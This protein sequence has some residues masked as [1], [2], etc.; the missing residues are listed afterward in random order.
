MILFILMSVFL[1]ILWKKGKN[2]IQSLFKT[3]H[4]THY[5]NKGSLRISVVMPFSSQDIPQILST[6]NYWW[7][8][9][10]TAYPCAVRGMSDNVI[11]SMVLLYDKDLEEGHDPSPSNID[12]LAPHSDFVPSPLATSADHSAAKKLR[13]RIEFAEVRK[14]WE[15]IGD[16]SEER[17]RMAKTL[18][19]SHIVRLLKLKWGHYGFGKCFKGG[20]KFISAKS[21]HVHE[22]LA[23]EN[24]CHTFKRGLDIT[25]RMNQDYI[26]YMEPTV[27]PIRKFWLDRIVKEI[28]KRNNDFFQRGALGFCPKSSLTDLG[29]KDYHINRNAIYHVKN[30]QFRRY[31]QRV[32]S[33]YPA[34]NAGIGES[35]CCTG[36]VDEIGV[37]VAM[38]QFIRHPANWND[39]VNF[40]HKFQY[41]TVFMNLCDR[42]VDLKQFKDTHPH[43]FLVQ[44]KFLSMKREEQLM[45]GLFQEILGNII[46]PDYS[47]IY[48][49]PI[50]DIIRSKMQKY[51]YV[52]AIEVLKKDNDLLYPIC[53][54]RPY[55]DNFRSIGHSVHHPLCTQLCATHFA[56]KL[57]A[58]ADGYCKPYRQQE[59]EKWDKPLRNKMYLWTTDFHAAPI[60]CNMKLLRSVGI[61]THPEIDYGNCV[62]FPGTCKE[63]LKVLEIDRWRGMS[64]DPC[65]NKIRKDF[66]NAY[67]NDPEMQRVDAII[68]SH[69][70]ANCELYMP[71][72]KSMIIYATTRLEFGRNDRF[73][74]WRTPY[75]TDANKYR[76]IEWINN[77]R[78]IAANPRNII[79]ANNLYDAKYI[80]YH[81]GIEV[82]YIPSWC[83]DFNT[84][85]NP[86]RPEI[87]L[88]PYRDNLNFPTF[89]EKL[90][91]KHPIM[92]SLL[93]AAA[94]TGTKLKFARLRQLY[95]KYSL[96][97]LA[98]H[99]AMVITPYQV[100][101]MSFFEYYRLNIP[102][103]VPSK[104]LIV[105]W[106][107]KYNNM[108]E[109]VYGDPE[110]LVDNPRN[111]SSPYLNTKEAL[112][113]WL[114]FSDY[115]VFP[116]ITEFDSHE[117]LI[118]KLETADL[119]A[120][121][122]KMR[123]FNRKQKKELKETWTRIKD[124]ILGHS[125][126]PGNSRMPRNIQEG[127]D[128]YGVSPLYDDINK[129]P[130][131]TCTD[132][133]T[134]KITE[135]LT[136]ERNEKQ[137]QILQG[138]KE[139]PREQVIY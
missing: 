124:K 135:Q 66:F 16:D 104:A 111:I 108:W 65:P 5:Y 129:Y 47:K 132:L 112:E 102:L 52:E 34:G 21:P 62:H 85:Y 75:M 20:L 119:R 61:E 41:T 94:S 8:E 114:P 6:W 93:V 122:K 79:A 71:F 14:K 26:Y 133:I 59:L 54:S 42:V 90:A 97:D 39:T 88:G 103:F 70:V 27:I 98:A 12:S 101:V 38:F 123:E 37:E 105:E 121:S 134:E 125:G 138:L 91:W 44:S 89:D 92:V 58:N 116:H 95:P 96:S 48:T 137:S 87:I 50:L 77:I 69:P 28:L 130:D 73:I 126:G 82:E 22:S 33:F 31:L 4:L 84:T 99:P 109:R 18:R 40:L 118:K 115:Y 1:T 68:C 72:N 3:R 51:S 106:S 32:Y 81:T 64:L 30:Q 19:G 86:T 29:K 2:P 128:M 9:E 25:Y 10:E 45:R 131:N 46:T 110:L 13:D 43:T 55:L 117:D 53:T 56:D 78:K 63:R 17:L 139:K 49:E 113:Y 23:P 76:W 67:R 107:V 60:G 127:L 57:D 100:S 83:G 136:T 36:Y 15:A 120:I 11:L 24:N 74:D 35:G 80:T 7:S